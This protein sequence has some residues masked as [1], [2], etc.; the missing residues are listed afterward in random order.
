VYWLEGPFRGEQV[1]EKS[2]LSWTWKGG[3]DSLTHAETRSIASIKNV[4]LP[5][6]EWLGRIPYS[7]DVDEGRG[8]PES[9]AL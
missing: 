8:T 5:N 4:D 9:G 6:K 3:L 2:V 7:E 1:I